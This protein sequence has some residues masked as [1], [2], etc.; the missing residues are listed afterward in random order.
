V[1]GGYDT[2]FDGVVGPWFLPAF[3]TATGLEWLHY[4][5]L[6]PSLERCVVRVRTRQGHGFTDEAATRHMHEQFTRAM[7]DQRHVIVDPPDD[8]DDVAALVLAAVGDESLIYRSP[9]L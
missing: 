8:V 6:M 7:I 2:V 4:V 9:P 3:A 1:S 5:I